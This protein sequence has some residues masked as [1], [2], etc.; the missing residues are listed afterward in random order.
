MKYAVI[1]QIICH[2]VCY[3][4]NLSQK[5]LKSHNFMFFDLLQQTPYPEILI[6][7]QTTVQYI[8]FQVLLY[9]TYLILKHMLFNVL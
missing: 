8:L 1:T 9:S 4:K 5:Y 3:S 6:I 2:L 7:T